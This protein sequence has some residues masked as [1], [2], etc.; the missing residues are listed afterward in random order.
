MIG[1]EEWLCE[2]WDWNQC[3]LS[4]SK[5]NLRNMVWNQWIVKMIE[6]C[7]FRGLY[8]HV[9][10]VLT[11]DWSPDGGNKLISSGMDHYLV[12]WDL[13]TEKCKNAINLSYKY[14]NERDEKWVSTSVK[15]L[16]LLQWM[17]FNHYHGFMIGTSHCNLRKLNGS[18][19]HFVDLGWRIENEI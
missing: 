5:N 12:L 4:L 14:N 11:C 9:D 10:E 6:S 13:S 16:D 7:G 1:L 3:I 8:G 2:V 18:F 19:R 15:I 17:E